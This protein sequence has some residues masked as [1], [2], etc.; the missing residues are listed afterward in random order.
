[1][2]G[3]ALNLEVGRRREAALKS[4]TAASSHFHLVKVLAMGIIG[5]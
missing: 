1:M 3:L 4:S 2:N 5:S